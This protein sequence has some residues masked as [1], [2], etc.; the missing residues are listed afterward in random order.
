MLTKSFLIQLGRV[1]DAFEMDKMFF[2]VNAIDLA[3]DAEE[4]EAVKAYVGEELQKVR[5]SSS[6]RAWAV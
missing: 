3:K 4:T 2:I 1:K 5:D 6:A